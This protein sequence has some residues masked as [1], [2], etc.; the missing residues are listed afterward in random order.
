MSMSKAFTGAALLIYYHALIQAHKKQGTQ[1]LTA[2]ANSP[3][4]QLPFIFSPH[5]DPPD[6][7]EKN[8]SYGI[9]WAW[10]QLPI[11]FGAMSPNG[12]CMKSKQTVGHGSD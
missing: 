10:T 7:I 5:M 1:G 2:D 3:F 8:Q 12:L 9:G 11:T 4:K 6:S